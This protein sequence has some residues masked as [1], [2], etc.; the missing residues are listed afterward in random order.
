MIVK[1]FLNRLTPGSARFSG[2]QDDS[3]LQDLQKEYQSQR[4]K[5]SLCGLRLPY[6]LDIN[7]HWLD[8]RCCQRHCRNWDER[9][10]PLQQMA[11]EKRTRDNHT[12]Q[13]E[14]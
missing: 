12:V 3:Q 11:S 1:I 10:A 9:Y 14:W 13:N 8:S 5:L 2:H 6:T 7:M 4:K